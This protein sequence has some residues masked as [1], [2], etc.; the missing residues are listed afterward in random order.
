MSGFDERCSLVLI[1][2]WHWMH[3]T[4]SYGT[5]VLDI[6]TLSC[7]ESGRAGIDAARTLSDSAIFDILQR[8]V[9]AGTLLR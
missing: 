6:V 3:L 1:I 8:R 7:F 4:V 5:R 2:T 9:Y